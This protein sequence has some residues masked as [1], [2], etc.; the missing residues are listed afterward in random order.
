MNKEHEKIMG[1]QLKKYKKILENPDKIKG[2][3]VQKVL[4]VMRTI[5]KLY[6]LVED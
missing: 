2:K 6:K 1:E 5:D 4:M 3:N